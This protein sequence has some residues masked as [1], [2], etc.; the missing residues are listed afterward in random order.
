M[1]FNHVQP[2]FDNLKLREAVLNLVDQKDYMQAA[3]GDPKYWKTCVA[4]FGCGTP[5]ADRGR[6]RRAAARRPNP[7]KAQS[8]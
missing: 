2:P 8:N 1:R 6:R 7:A 3:A 4:L 5:L